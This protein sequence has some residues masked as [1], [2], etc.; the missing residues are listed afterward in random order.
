MSINPNWYPCVVIDHPLFEIY[1]AGPGHLES[2][3]RVIAIRE[4][5]RN[6]PFNT[7][8]QFLEPRDAQLS[9]IAL[10]HNERYI[11]AIR[12]LCEAGGAYIPSM[13]ATVTPISWESAIKAAGAGLTLAD[14]L[15]K[16]GDENKTVSLSGGQRIGSS[17]E[18]IP[19]FSFALTRPPGH[20]AIREKPMGFCIFNNIAITARYLL[21]ERGWQR[22]AIV[23]FDV[24]HGNG[25]QEAFWTDDRVL[26]VSF[27]RRNLYPYGWGSDKEIGEGMGKG[28]T[29]NLPLDPGAGDDTYRQLWEEKVDPALLEF[30]P[31][32]VLV[33]AGFDAHYLDPLGGMR[34]TQKGYQMIGQK[35][36]S[37]V[38]KS[39][40]KGL[41]AL[42]EGG[43]DLRGLKEGVT[44]FLQGVLQK[45]TEEA[46]KSD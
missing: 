20:H 2:P 45:S 6:A 41:L 18:V 38:M 26:F 9:E 31:Q 28:Y 39:S 29:L 24:H 5:L 1:E 32:I 13:E 4:A 35:L 44:G 23:D 43:Y 15:T 14:L 10:V 8:L 25:T 17:K 12:R 16:W 36:Q 34:L 30:H 33:S 22:I 3:E 7:I 46:H 19:F 27:H 21:E 40:A 11:E 42:L 37:I